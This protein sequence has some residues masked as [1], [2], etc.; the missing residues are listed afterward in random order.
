MPT[1]PETPFEL[2]GGCFCSAIRYKISVPELE[3]RPKV[4]SNPKAEISPPNKVSERLPMISLDHCTSCRRIAGAIIESWIIIPQAW[5]QFALQPRTN[6]STSPD[7]LIKPTTIEYL[8]PDKAIQEKTYLTY[9][10]SSETSNR[11]FCGKCGTHLTFYYS[12]TPGEQSMRNKWGPYFDVAGGTL[13]KESLEM[14]GYKPGRHVWADDGIDWV[15]K[16]L[17][18]GENSLRD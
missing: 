6:A 11:T 2:N 17:K 13:D 1:L 7:Q 9:F 18:E 8:M 14:E 10:E 15:K 3:L 4:D 16:L 5:V 12:G